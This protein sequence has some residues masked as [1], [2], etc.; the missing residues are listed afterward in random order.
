MLVL[1][2]VILAVILSAP[3]ASQFFIIAHV[4]DSPTQYTS[5]E[6][7]P[8]ADLVKNVTI[9]ATGPKDFGDTTPTGILQPTFQVPGGTYAIK[10]EK[11]GYQTTTVNYM[12]GPNCDGKDQN[13][14]C[15]ALVRI[16]KTL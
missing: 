5:F 1:A 2:V 14:I 15:H 8:V 10:A 9:T 4:Y 13:G 11:P 12:V 6:N 16:L 3:P 7:I